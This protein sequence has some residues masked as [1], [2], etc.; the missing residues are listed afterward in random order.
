MWAAIAAAG[1]YLYKHQQTASAT[2]AVA[3][4]TATPAALPAPMVTAPDV[5]PNEMDSI[6]PYAGSVTII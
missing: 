4:V 3:T 5:L 6:N 2:P 1:Y